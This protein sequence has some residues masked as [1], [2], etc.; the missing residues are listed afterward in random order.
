MTEKDLKSIEDLIREFLLEETT[1]KKIPDKKLEFGFQFLFPPGTDPSGR[2]VGQNMAV[3]KPKDKDLVII[4]LGTQ[5]SPPHV[6]ALDSLKDDGKQRFFLDL[7]KILLIKNLMFRIDVQNHRYEISE[8]YFVSKKKFLTKNAFYKLVRK[9]FSCAAYCH[10]L[11][12][13]Y[14]SGK[15]KSEDL[16]DSRDFISGPGFSLYS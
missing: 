10:I 5:I 16:S 11:L 13:E 3:I 7:R 15:I 1:I 8:Q 14:C 9:V 4:T 12:N 2:P 6:E